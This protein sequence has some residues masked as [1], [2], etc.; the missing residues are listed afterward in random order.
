M[1]KNSCSISLV[2]TGYKKPCDVIINGKLNVKKTSVFNDDV[3]MEEDLYVKGNAEFNTSSDG[4]V[5]MRSLRSVDY[6]STPTEDSFITMF[7]SKQFIRTRSGGSPQYNAGFMCSYFDTS[8]FYIYNSDSTGNLKISYNSSLTGA[9]GGHDNADDCVDILPH[10][11]VLTQ[12]VSSRKRSRCHL[13]LNQESLFIQSSVLNTWVTFSDLI[14]YLPTPTLGTELTNFTFTTS[15]PTKTYLTY[16]D[17]ITRYFLVKYKITAETTTSEIFFTV[18]NHFVSS[19]GSFIRLEQSKSYIKTNANVV[20]TFVGEAMVKLE[21]NDGI[22]MTLKNANSNNNINIYSF[23][24]MA[25]DMNYSG[26]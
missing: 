22:G 25:Y 3:T 19:T 16:D 6:E 5:S 4:Y 24:L 13:W 9:G 8:N 11:E 15:G 18:I 26:E 12:Y 2:P 14:D 20:Y 17:T 21:Q 10:A 7:G 23:S 1:S